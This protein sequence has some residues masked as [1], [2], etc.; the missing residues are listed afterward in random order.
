M[1]DGVESDGSVVGDRIACTV[2]KGEN[3]D[4]W[5]QG[6]RKVPESGRLEG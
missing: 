4:R 6:I 5:M 3:W 1:S 2:K